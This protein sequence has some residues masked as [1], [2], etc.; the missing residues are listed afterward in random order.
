[1]IAR[2]IARIGRYYK[3]AGEKGFAMDL[4]LAFR[5]FFTA[6]GRGEEIVR[7]QRVVDGVKDPP[8]IKEITREVVIPQRN[9][10]IREVP[11]EVIKEIRVEVPV[12]I[13]REV[14]VEVIKEVIKEV[15]V[16]VVREVIKEV[17]IEII[18]EVEK[19][20]IKEVLVEVIKEVRVEVP[21]EVINEVTREVPV[22]VIKE[23]IKEVPVEVIKEVRVEVPV[24]IIKE[25]TREVPV[26]RSSRS[27]QT[28]VAG[29]EQELRSTYGTREMIRETIREVP[30]ETVREI[31]K[32]IP[33]THGP[34]QLLGLLQQDGRLLDFLFENI[35]EYDDERVGAAA[36]EIH[37]RCRKA[38]LKYI[39]FEPVRGER[40]GEMV[41]LGSDYDPASIRVSGT[42][43]IRS[44]MFGTLRHRGWRAARID[45]PPRPTGA[46]PA[47]VMPAEVEVE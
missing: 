31:I 16:E 38:L 9:P 20:V 45:L 7:L 23:V 1:M 47:I 39:T 37:A 33:D 30:V 19:E 2:Q 41:T 40:E 8:V 43:H 15:P 10:I 6:L 21:V 46:D 29:T 36:R 22:E 32:R 3:R 5:C 35:D 25:V 44:A 11:V 12:E 24:E 34:A 18:K 4:G 14:P 26:E 28:G 42:A 27:V 17:P 13:I